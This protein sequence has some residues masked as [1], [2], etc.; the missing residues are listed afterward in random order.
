MARAIEELFGE[1]VHKGMINVKYGFTEHL[2]HGEII[3]AGHPLPDENSVQ[4]TRK[5]IDFLASAGEKDLVFSLISGVDLPY[6]AGRQEISLYP[7]NRKLR[8]CCWLVVPVSM[9]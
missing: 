3:E 2:R 9:R 4:G 1:K 7:K 8:I 5:I 6:C